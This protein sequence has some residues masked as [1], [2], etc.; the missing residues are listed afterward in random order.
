M[1]THER[2]ILFHG[3]EADFTCSVLFPLKG[4]FKLCVH[5][6]SMICLIYQISKEGGFSR[7]KLDDRVKRKLRMCVFVCVGGRVGAN[8]ILKFTSTHEVFGTPFFPKMIY[9]N[10]ASHCVK[11]ISYLKTRLNQP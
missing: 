9:Q 1:F 11:G 7:E 4:L 2:G 6:F 5:F 3:E 10:S 8:Y